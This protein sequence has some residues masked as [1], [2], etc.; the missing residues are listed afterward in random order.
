MKISKKQKLFIFIPLIIGGGL[1]T[2]MLILGV[3]PTFNQPLLEFP[4][5]EENNIFSI[6]AYGIEN[7]SGPGTYHN[8]IDLV[9]NTSVTIVSPVKGTVIAITEHQNEHSV[10]QNILFDIQIQIN[11]G[12]TVKLVLEPNF[13]GEDVY[14]NTLQRESISVSLF[15]RLEVGSQIAT[16]LYS[17][18]YSHLHYMLGSFPG[19]VCP[20][21]Y[22]SDQAKSIFNAITL[23]TNQSICV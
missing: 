13:P 20:F 1:L 10:I 6:S 22:S 16:L 4:I 8:G 14:N 11:W 9:I 15:Q 19:E 12:W 17:G 7:W 5:L 18:Y 23:R 3:P 2:Y 21:T